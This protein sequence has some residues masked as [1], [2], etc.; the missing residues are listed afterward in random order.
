MDFLLNLL[1]SCTFDYA[2]GFMIYYL[3][4]AFIKIIWQIGV[5]KIC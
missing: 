4:V 3:L 5:G 2:L 1:D